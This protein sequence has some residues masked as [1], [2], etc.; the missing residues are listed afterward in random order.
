MVEVA[1]RN[2]RSLGFEISGRVADAERLPYDNGE[3][4][5]VVG[6]AVLHHIPDVEL[7]FREVLRVLRPGGRF[8]FA[9]EPTRYGDAC[10]M[11]PEGGRFIRMRSDPTVRPGR[12][13]SRR[14]R[15]ALR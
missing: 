9:G 15:R 1:Q 7:A 8:V 13:A 3:F 12:T 14:P 11:P 10:G 2:A 6:H 5:L 4:D